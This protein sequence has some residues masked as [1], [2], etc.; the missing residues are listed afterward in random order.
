VHKTHPRYLAKIKFHHHYPSDTYYSYDSLCVEWSPDSARV[1][2]GG[3]AG[4]LI[5]N[6]RRGDELWRTRGI[7]NRR[8]GAKKKRGGQRWAYVTCL[9]HSPDGALVAVGTFDHQ[10]ALFEAE[11]G[12]QRSGWS[13]RGPNTK[14]QAVAWSPDSSRIAFVTSEGRLYFWEAAAL[15]LGE[16]PAWTIG[17]EGEAVGVSFALTGEYLLTFGVD[18]VLRSRALGKRTKSY[19]VVELDGRGKALDRCGDELLLTTSEGVFLLDSERRVLCLGG[20]DVTAGCWIGGSREF[21]GLKMRDGSVGIFLRSG[22]EIERWSVH[23]SGYESA[24]HLAASPDGERLLMLGSEVNA[25]LARTDDLGTDIELSPPV[26]VDR[27]ARLLAALEAQ[28]VETSDSSSWYMGAPLDWDAPGEERWRRELPRAQAQRFIAD[29]ARVYLDALSDSVGALDANDGSVAWFG[30]AVRPCG[31]TVAPSPVGWLAGHRVVSLTAGMLAFD[32]DGETIWRAFADL[33]TD[34]G[35]FPIAFGDVII[36]GSRLFHRFAF[37]AKTGLPIWSDAK[38]LHDSQS[39]ALSRDGYFL[40]RWN[41]Q[42]AWFLHGK[43]VPE[44]TNKNTFSAPPLWLDEHHVV[45]AAYDLFPLDIRDGSMPWKIRLS[46]GVETYFIYHGEDGAALI[47]CLFR[48]GALEARSSEDGALVWGLPSLELEKGEK[49]LEVTIAGDKILVPR[50]QE[51]W[52]LDAARGEVC[53]VQALRERIT[54]PVVSASGRLYIACGR[55]IHAFARAGSSDAPSAPS[56][57]E[58]KPEPVRPPEQS[59]IAPWLGRVRVEPYGRIFDADEELVLLG[60]RTSVFACSTHD[61]RELWRMYGG[62][63]DPPSG[64]LLDASRCFVVLPVNFN[65]SNLAALDRRDGRVLWSRPLLGGY[66]PK[67][68]GHHAGKILLG[69]KKDILAIDPDTG[70]ELWRLNEIIDEHHPKVGV[71]GALLLSSY[72]K[73][74][75]CHDEALNEVWSHEV[76]VT[77]LAVDAGIA[78]VAG[79][80]GCIAYASSTGEVLWELASPTRIAKA[81]MLAGQGDVILCMAERLLR[82]SLKDGAILWEQPAFVGSNL[83]FAIAERFV[84]LGS[85]NHNVLCCH[86]ISTGERVEIEQPHERLFD[87]H[88]VEEHLVAF[89]TSGTLACFRAGDGWPETPWRME[90]RTYETTPQRALSGGIPTDRA[91]ALSWIAP[92]GSSRSRSFGAC[93]LDAP[94]HEQCIAVASIQLGVCLVDRR[95]GDVRWR[96]EE[97]GAARCVHPFGGVLAVLSSS[98]QIFGLDIEDGHVCWVADVPTKVL[99]WAVGEEHIVVITQDQFVWWIDVSG[100]PVGFVELEQPLEKVWSIDLERGVIFSPRRTF[101]PSSGRCLWERGEERVEREDI[102]SE[103]VCLG[104]HD[105]TRL[106]GY[107]IEDGAWLWEFSTSPC[108]RMWVGLERLEERAFLMSNISYSAGSAFLIC[109]DVRDGS[110]LWRVKIGKGADC[111]P[112]LVEEVVLVCEY[113]GKIRALDARTGEER[114]R[115]DLPEGTRSPVQILPHEDGVALVDISGVTVHLVWPE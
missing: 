15:A 66:H 35:K 47:L 6:D 85:Y 57:L 9:A 42:K 58:V 93:L 112:A 34:R 95:S 55:S 65:L 71:D 17:L 94:G 63:F 13:R 41:D 76:D 100:A 91:P 28:P 26:V 10:V 43:E 44:W 51:L 98:D 105:R 111:A 46:R 108:D 78:L 103:D 69:Q 40:P 52:V 89:G 114:W 19:T 81:A 70:A 104:I 24:F 101:E 86:D 29:D 115:F 113:E 68:L 75:R 61:G 87:L 22:E 77:L 38:K 48:D 7:R 5:A 92:L 27:A 54:A 74:L 109:V 106:R 2:T 18:G 79:G 97:V 4:S 1:V 90:T 23:F 62:S 102:A 64:G 21:I 50:G 3:M 82:V 73:V 32:Q 39:I 99:G 8:A 60:D 30:P 14:M 110:E 11:T 37:D 45:S 36:D 59:D 25:Y 49:P 53:F 67:I 83:A 80:A 16:K 20:K 107:A 56:A 31:G 72:R 88:V 84:Y 12:K 96:S 33:P